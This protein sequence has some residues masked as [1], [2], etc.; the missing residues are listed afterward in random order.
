MCFSLI[1]SLTGRDEFSY[2][3]SCIDKNSLYTFSLTCNAANKEVMEL[4]EP[5]K[6]TYASVGYSISLIKWAMENGCPFQE[7]IWLDEAATC[8]HLTELRWL[9]EKTKESEWDSSDAS[10][11]AALGGHLHVLEWA[12]EKNKDLSYVY[13]YAALGGHINVLKWAL[14]KNI[15]VG[16]SGDAD[17]K[18]CVA[19]S[20]AEGGQREVLDW[21][22][23]NGFKWDTFTCV[24]AAAG[25]H[26]DVL[27]WLREEGCDWTSEVYSC[28]AKGGHL[29]IVKWAHA[30]GCWPSDCDICGCAAEGGHFEILQWAR[31]NGFP[32]GHTMWCAARAKNLEILK[33]AYANGCTC[34]STRPIAE[35]DVPLDISLAI[36][37]WVEDDLM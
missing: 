7:Q 32:W 3:V 9:C 29:D 22:R 26:L 35:G 20:A 15:V 6:T 17:D 28:A 34:T 19:N 1:E 37:R 31:A 24:G 30:N 5:I 4:K 10:E 14:E 13:I 27:H 8:G 11:N 21:L 12:Y 25:G 36:I 2:L 33:W 16:E 23:K 18:S